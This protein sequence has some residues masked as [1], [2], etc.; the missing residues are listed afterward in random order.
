MS[1]LESRPRLLDLFSGEGGCS[2]GYYR[3][4]FDVVGVDSKPMPGY[5]Y[6]FIEADAMEVVADRTFLAGFD[7]VAASP[8]CPR[9]SRMTVARGNSG[10]HPDL[11]GPVTAALREWGGLYVVENVPGAPM[12]NPIVLCGSE[13]GLGALCRDG[14]WRQLR[15]HRHFDSNVPILRPNGCAHRGEPVGVYG[16][17]GSGPQRVNRSRRGYQA[18]RAEGAEALGIDWMTH[19]KQLANAIPPAYTEYL[20]GWLRDHLNEVAA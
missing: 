1:T 8:P 17:G 3:A 18:T 20:G 9:Y 4:G 5:P 15:R 7:A 6:E 19:Q 11:V 13:F 12:V 16:H 2:V 10:D 14:V